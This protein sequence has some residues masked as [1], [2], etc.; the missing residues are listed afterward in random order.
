MGVLCAGSWMVDFVAAHLPSMPEPGGLVYAP[1]G[2]DLRVGGHSANVAVDLVQLGQLDV[3]SA[4]CVGDD[5]LGRFVED[6]LRSSGVL[7]RPLK[8]RDTGTAKNVALVVEGEDKRFVAEFAANTELTPEH[9]E[10][11]LTELS[12]SVFYLGTVGGLKHIDPELRRVLK[13][14]RDGGAVTVLDVIM[15]ENGWRHLTAAYPYIDFLH[16]NNI[17]AAGL[18]GFTDASRAARQFTGAGVGV[19]IVS[20]GNRGLVAHNGAELIV[21]P[22]FD[23]V[24][25]DPTG[26]GD[27]LCAGLIHHISSLGVRFPPMIQLKEALMEASAAGAAC[28]TETGATTSVTSG[29]VD[30]LLRAQGA[31]LK[32]RIRVTS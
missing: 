23:V 4:G 28:V 10:T 19:A 5:V 26:A 7:S 12:P 3:T 24:E 11:A 8:L 13:T 6:S 9:V 16:C 29:K 27:A 20:L 32:S 2:I 22:Q 1:R 15:P 14:A 18:T 17:E 25:V 31:S 30:T 21:V